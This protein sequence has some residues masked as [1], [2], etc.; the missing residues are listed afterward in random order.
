MSGS[1]TEMICG[2]ERDPVVFVYTD[3]TVESVKVDL[4]LGLNHKRDIS[5]FVLFSAVYLQYFTLFELRF[6]YQA[7]IICTR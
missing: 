5:T 2:L 1:G 4:A 7:Q 6:V 3:I